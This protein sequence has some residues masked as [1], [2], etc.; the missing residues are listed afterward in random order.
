MRGNLNRPYRQDFSE[1]QGPVTITR[2]GLLGAGWQ[3]LVSGEHSAT[4]SRVLSLR[5]KSG[6]F[7]GSS[8]K[9]KY[10][11]HRGQRRPCNSR[12]VQLS[13]MV[14]GRPCRMLQ[15]SLTESNSPL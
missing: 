10:P 11:S 14:A 7:G 4:Q 1:S 6:V 3:E 8:A 15:F 13:M 5:D 12:L 2:D 9:F